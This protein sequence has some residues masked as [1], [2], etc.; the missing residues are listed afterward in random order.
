MTTLRAALLAL[1]LS[2]DCRLRLATTSC[3]GPTPSAGRTRDLCPIPAH[4]G[5]THPP[6]QPIRQPASG[7]RG[8]SL[9][10]IAAP[11]APRRTTSAARPGWRSTRSPCCWPFRPRHGNSRPRRHDLPLWSHGGL[12]GS[13]CR[14]NHKPLQD[15]SL[16][17]CRTVGPLWPDRCFMNGQTPEVPS[18][19]R[20]TPPAQRPSPCLP[21]PSASTE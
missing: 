4:S 7:G 18:S 14:L 9:G 21:D 11:P 17:D 15:N 1:R 20:R 19:T 8:E 5:V 12:T 3:S 16:Q 13:I 6:S 2:Q 10:R